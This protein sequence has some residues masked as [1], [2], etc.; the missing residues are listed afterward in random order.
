MA[1]VDVH[2]LGEDQD[3]G[4]GLLAL[5]V[6][7]RDAGA[8]PDAVGGR[9]GVG[10]LADLVEPLMQLAEPGL[11]ELLPLERRLV[12][13]ILPEVAHL[14]RLGDGLGQG[15]GE[16]VGERFDFPPELFAHFRNHESFRQKKGRAREKRTLSGHMQVSDS[17]MPNTGRFGQVGG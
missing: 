7:H 14:H 8:Q 2:H 10:E 12:L 11:H 6:Q 5:Q 9:L 16:L 13:G 3:V 1:G 17:K 15:D 4:V